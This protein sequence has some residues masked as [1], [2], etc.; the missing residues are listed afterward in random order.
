LVGLGGLVDFISC[1]LNHGGAVSGDAVLPFMATLGKQGEIKF[2]STVSEQGA[3]FMACG[4]GRVTGW[5]GV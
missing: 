4:E 5:P 3:S 1:D 2:Y